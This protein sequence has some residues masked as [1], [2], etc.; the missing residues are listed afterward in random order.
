MRNNPTRCRDNAFTEIAQAEAEIAQCMADFVCCILD[1]LKHDRRSSI[2]EKVE[3]FRCLI[4]ASATKEKAIADVVN[5]L[6]NNNVSKKGAC[7]FPGFDNE[8]DD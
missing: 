3:L 8:D 2:E 6:A 7:D 4:L 5:A 1:E